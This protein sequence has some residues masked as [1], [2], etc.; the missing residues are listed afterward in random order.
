M[1]THN[2]VFTSATYQQAPTLGGMLSQAQDRPTTMTVRGTAMKTLYLLLITIVTAIFSWN[3]FRDNQSLITPT[4]IGSA[5]GSIAFG[6]FMYKKPNLAQWIVPLFA[7]SEGL[8]V[9][10]FSVAVVYYSSLSKAFP[11][12]QAAFETVGQAAGLTLSIAG[13]M[14]FGYATGVLRL[15]GFMKKMI[16]VMTAGVMFYYL[17]AWIMSFILPGVIPNLGW[18]GGAIGIGFSVVVVVLASLNLLLDFQF[19]DD[20]VKRGLPKS[21]EWFGAFGILVT[22]V[23]LYIEV[24]RLLAKLKSD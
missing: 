15:S 18:E 2:P 4:I 9:A 12:E 20:G 3:T 13:A 6:F 1:R 8:L 14:L 23:W 19:I 17:A 22:L 10:A 7:F 11:S 5:I 24:L 16:I 21:Y